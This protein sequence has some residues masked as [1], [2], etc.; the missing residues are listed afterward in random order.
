LED[1]RIKQAEMKRLEDEQMNKD[2]DERVK[3]AAGL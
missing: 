3:A 2:E 1:E